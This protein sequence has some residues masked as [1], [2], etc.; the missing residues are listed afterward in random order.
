LHT[1]FAS[2]VRLIGQLGQLRGE[3]NGQ[4]AMMTPI[5]SSVAG[6]PPSVAD[7]Q[8]AEIASRQP[9]GINEP[10]ALT[11]MY[12]DLP[13][14]I[15]RLLARLRRRPLTPSEIA[16]DTAIQTTTL[17]GDQQRAIRLHN[18]LTM[19]CMAMNMP[20]PPP[21]PAGAT[22]PRAIH[23][24]YWIVGIGL[25]WIIASWLWRKVTAGTSWSQG[26]TA[27]GDPY[28]M[29]PYGMNGMN[30]MSGYNG[31]YGGMGGMGM[32]MSGFGGYGSYGSGYGRY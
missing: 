12:R 26:G 31:L 19:R 22:A 5:A 16:E 21:L 14:R 2:G 7:R 15:R 11:I 24:M 29:S 3:M 17:H 9:G 1:S 8:A 18:E 4:N 23:P 10:S 28:A 13:R 27:P 30:G 25:S 6:Q 32:G 20:A